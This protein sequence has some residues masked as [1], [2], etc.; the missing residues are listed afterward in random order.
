M[1]VQDGK[2]Y[3]TGSVSGLLLAIKRPFDKRSKPLTLPVPEI[4]PLSRIRNRNRFY[5]TVKS[6]LDGVFS[7][8]DS[9]VCLSHTSKP[10]IADMGQ[11]CVCLNY[12]RNIVERNWRGKI[13]SFLSQV[14]FNNG[15]LRYHSE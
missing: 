12:Y 9:G 2:Q 8:R 13:F 10:R 1:R 15:V 14:L 4:S 6:F 3:G 5:I 11:N 7:D